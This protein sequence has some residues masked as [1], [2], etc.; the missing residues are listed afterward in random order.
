M[1]K[2]CPECRSVS[3]KKDGT[4]N[5]RQSY[6]CK[7]CG[8]VFQNSKRRGKDESGEFFERHAVRKQTAAELSEDS[9]L[10]VRTVHRRLDEAFAS[11]TAFL[12]S[13]KAAW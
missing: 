7:D 2:K 1:N 5:G 12:K 9:E 13:V 4:R 10:S 6:K 11:F 8:H 3:T